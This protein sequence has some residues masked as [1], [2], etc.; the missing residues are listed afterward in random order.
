M[1]YKQHFEFVVEKAFIYAEI[2]GQY[3]KIPTG[4]EK[5]SGLILETSAGRVLFSHYPIEPV[6]RTFLPHI[7][8]LKKVFEQTKC[9]LNIH[10]HLRSKEIKDR[11][12]INVSVEKISFR[13]VKL[14]ELLKTA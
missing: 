2:N 11:R 9:V 12:C 3:W 1:F 5:A 14:S 13:P 6:E 7:M 8:A 10:G 4:F